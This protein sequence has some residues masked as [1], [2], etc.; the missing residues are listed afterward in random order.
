M[1]DTKLERVHRYFATT[2]ALVTTIGNRYGPNVMAAEWAM[3]VSYDPMTIA[4]FIH[5]SP[6]YSNIRDSRTFGV[7]VASDEQAELVNLA[8]GYSGTEISKLD[9]PGAFSTYRGRK[10]RVPMIKDCVLNAECVVTEIREVGDHI[11]VLGKVIEAS[12]EES[13]FPLIYTRGNYR[14]VSR[15]KIASGRR[16]VMLSPAQLDEFERL[17]SGQFVLRAAACMAKREGK[18][19][20]QQVGGSWMAPFTKVPRGENYP[21]ALQTHLESIGHRCRVG[22]IVSVARLNLTDGR[23]SVRANFVVFRCT[24]RSKASAKTEWFERLPHRTIL[25]RQLLQDA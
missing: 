15:S 25:A 17:A 14:K 1:R 19:L 22:R 8:G 9:I 3:Q 16:Q 7:N 6:T 24:I 2:V 5:D 10:I 20:L 12:Y 23:R 21:R 18:W 11:M 4:V 13:K